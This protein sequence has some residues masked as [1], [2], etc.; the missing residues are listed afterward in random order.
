MDELIDLDLSYAPP[1]GSAK[2]PVN[3]IGM[4]GQNLLT[5][6]VRLWD[7]HDLDAVRESALVLDTRGA[8][9][10]ASG[11]IPGSL[12]IAHTE[13]RDRLD[14][15]RDAAAGRPVRVLCQSGVRSHISHRILAQAG[16]D[17]ASMSGGML[18]LRAVLGDR[19]ADVLTAP[20]N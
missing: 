18:T 13:L 10:Y 8:G 6:T 3:F 16:F 1:Y 7:A 9:E 17:S 12:N 20:E 2:D 15:V 14:E 19:A 5:D 4:I 11:H